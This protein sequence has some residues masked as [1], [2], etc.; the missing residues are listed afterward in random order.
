MTSIEKVFN[1]LEEQALFYRSLNNEMNISISASDYLDIK[2]LAKE[3]HKQE[4]IDAYNKSFELR[5]KPYSTA[6]KYY[7]ENYTENY[8][9]LDVSKG[10]GMSEKPNNHTNSEIPN[11]ISDISKMVQ[12]PQQEI[13]DEEIENEAERYKKLMVLILL[14]KQ[15]NGIENN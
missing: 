6:D 9:K 12:L 1:E 5:D 3:M 2:R 4:I 7:T 14:K 10:S 11:H 8:P 13:S 15:L